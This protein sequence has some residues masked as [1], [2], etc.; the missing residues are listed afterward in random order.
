MFISVEPINFFILTPPWRRWCN[1]WQ[2]LKENF[3]YWTDDLVVVWADASDKASNGTWSSELEPKN[4]K[5]GSV[6]RK[7]QGQERKLFESLVF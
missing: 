5:G 6:L 3:S 4:P 2:Y 7:S 1:V